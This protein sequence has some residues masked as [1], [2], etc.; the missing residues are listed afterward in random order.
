MVLQISDSGKGI[1]LEDLRSIFT[2]FASGKKMGMSGSGLGLVVVSS[3]IDD[4]G[5]YID[6][7]SELGRG[8]GFYIYLSAL[9][10]EADG[11][12]RDLTGVERI[13]VVDDNEDDR[14]DTCR[15]LDLLGYEVVSFSG[16][17]ALEYLKEHSVALVVLDLMLEFTNG[18]DLYSKII[19]ANPS[20]KGIIVSGFLNPIDSKRA[21]SLGIKRCIE[22]PV[23]RLRLGQA[24]RGELDRS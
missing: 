12:E 2:P 18:L 13:L 14:D 6:V 19:E 7:R 9:S 24:I 22:K 17:E 21:S 5:G 15:V 20:L 3:V 23:D 4:M 11:L 10:K 16:E 1:N 8:T